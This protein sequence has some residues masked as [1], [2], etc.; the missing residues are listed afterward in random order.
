M[1]DTSNRIAGLFT[2]EIAEKVKKNTHVF[3][4]GESNSFHVVIIWIFSERP[5]SKLNKSRTDD[6]NQKV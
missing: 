5:R 3:R 2:V 6:I 4:R 1:E